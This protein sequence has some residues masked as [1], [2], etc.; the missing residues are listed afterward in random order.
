[1]RK[2][3]LVTLLATPLLAS[4]NLH[5]YPILGLRGNF[6]RRFYLEDVCASYC[7]CIANS[8]TKEIKNRHR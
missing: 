1:M 6:Y 8:G 5:V 4:A 7:P 2:I 3:I